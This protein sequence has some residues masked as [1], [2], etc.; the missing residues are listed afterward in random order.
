MFRPRAFLAGV[1][2]LSAATLAMAGP[3]PAGATM[4]CAGSIK[5]THMAFRPSTVSPGQ[6]ST[7]HVV[8]VN[9]TGQSRQTTLTWLGRFV[10][11]SGGCPAIDPLPQ[12]ANFTPHGRFTSSLTYLVPAGC[13]ATSLQARAQFR[14]GGRV[15]AERTADLT[16]TRPSA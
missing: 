5:I 12:S 13:T 8:A 14:A 15:V 4:S 1:A 7:V 16:I 9:C 10:G 2:V 3:A 6:S 11:G